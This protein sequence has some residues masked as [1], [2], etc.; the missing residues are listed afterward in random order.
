MNKKKDGAASEGTAERLVRRIQIDYK[1]IA[2]ESGCTKGKLC[3]TTF[4][5]GVQNGNGA[6]DFC[7]ITPPETNANEELR[8]EGNDWVIY[9][10]NEKDQGR[11][12]P[13][14]D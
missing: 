14:K 11:D 7:C 9:T 8:I 12:A 4:G 2:K 13:R 6:A 5:W 10:S 3:K 1:A